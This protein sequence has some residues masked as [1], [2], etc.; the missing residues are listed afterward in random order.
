MK[1]LKNT[2]RIAVVQAAPVMFDKASCVDKAVALIRQAAAEGAELIVFPELFVPGYPYGMTFGFTVGSRGA[3]GRKDWGVYYEN[4]ILVPGPETARLSQAAKEAGAYVSIGVSERDEVS[5][6]LYNSNLV[7]APDGTLDAV[8]RKLK[9][10][11]AERVVWGDADKH[12]FPVTDTPW[13][14]MGSLICWESYMPLARV[15]LYEKGVTLYLSPNTN[16]NEEWQATIRHIAIEGHCF[17]VNADL[18]FTRDMYPRDLHCPEEIGRL[19]DLVCRGGS[20]VVDPYGHYV[21]E[22]VWDREAVIYADLD[23]SMAP[24]SRMEFDACG[25]YSRP[26]VLKLEVQDR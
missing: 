22:P 23:L 25:H 13:G 7:F 3:D 16:D 1:D 19:P 5:A 10:T 26:D 24:L 21:T 8:H 9:P 14:P 11:G 17:F 20:C 4:S 2:C 12:Y 18:F 15:A 6:T